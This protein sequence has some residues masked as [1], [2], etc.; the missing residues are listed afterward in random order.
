MMRVVHPEPLR[1]AA[2]ANC[3]GTTVFWEIFVIRY[4]QSIKIS[5]LLEDMQRTKSTE[6][7]AETPFSIDILELLLE[8]FNIT[9]RVQHDMNYNR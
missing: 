2:A 5:T 3:I 9:Y 8:Y 7:Q 1:N 6:V 4:G